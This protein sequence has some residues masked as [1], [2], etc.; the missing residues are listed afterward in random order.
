M[1]PA[2]FKLTGFNGLTRRVNFPERPSWGVL[3]TRISELYGIPAQH[4]AVSYLDADGDEITLSSEQELVELYETHEPARVIKFS[5]RDLTS[6]FADGQ[7]LAETLTT[8]PT[9]AHTRNTFGQAPS[10][11]ED[12]DWHELAPHDQRSG[13]D[14]M[15]VNVPR[16]ASVYSD[17]DSEEE[18]T[19]LTRPDK[20]KDKAVFDD[21]ASSTGSVLAE[22]TPRKPPIHI[23]DISH[24]GSRLPSPRAPS[25]ISHTSQ[26]RPSPRME[27]GNVS[28]DVPSADNSKDF[29]AFEDPP[30]PTVPPRPAPTPPA[31]NVHPSFSA[32]FANFMTALNNAVTSHPDLSEA[33]NNLIRNSSQGTYWTGQPTFTQSTEE[34]VGQANRAAEQATRAAEQLQR[35][36]EAD[37]GR[38]VTEIFNNVFQSFSDT[39][40]TNNREPGNN[41]SNRNPNAETSTSEFWYAPFH[42]SWQHPQGRPQLRH[43]FNTIW[44]M[45][46]HHPH[47]H[48]PP[49]PHP[50]AFPPPPPP[51][52]FPPPF[53][54]PP[55]VP[56]PPPAMPPTPGPIPGAF[57]EFPASPTGPSTK[58]LRDE[59]ERARHAYK[60]EKERYRE[61][62]RREKENKTKSP[63]H[64]PVIPNMSSIHTGESS[65]GDRSQTEYFG[66]PRRSNTHLGTGHSAGRH[67]RDRSDR[68]ASD[69]F[70][71]RTVS[72]ISKR[73]GDMGFTEKSHPDLL[74]IIKSQVPP[75]GLVV[76]KDAEDHLVTTL[77]EQLLAKATLKSEGPSASGSGMNI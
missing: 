31:S 37:V 43:R 22:S 73:L 61:E 50:P 19:P 46:R 39:T 10:D 56:P 64:S 74:A 70:T 7:P 36:I 40:N 20:G 47:P 15:Y 24:D 2:H 12:T 58:E 71:S 38:R 25:V 49:P 60:L 17:S 35:N 75:H 57:P 76:D 27:T 1:P 66:F 18:T 52:V 3:S 42:R 9:T 65:S 13:D 72:R 67:D 53:F 48:P 6:P 16:K 29:E 8:S 34:I 21:N 77:L 68:N 14:T 59:V 23:F 30:F 4:A 55:Y 69:N 51:P 11:M 62:R 5:I 63:K 45:P 26:A 41:N 28:M 33:F 54:A 44:G 32:D